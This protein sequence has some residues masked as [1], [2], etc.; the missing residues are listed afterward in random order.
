[1]FTCSTNWSWA[2]S[3]LTQPNLFNCR[4]LKHGKSSNWNLCFF[5][6]TRGC[7]TANRIQRI[8]FTWN[9]WKSPRFVGCVAKKLFG[10]SQATGGSWSNLHL[11]EQRSYCPQGWRHGIDMLWKRCMEI[12]ATSLIVVLKILLPFSVWYSFCWFKSQL[13][14]ELFIHH[15]HVR[16]TGLVRGLLLQRGYRCLHALERN[17]LCSAT[18]WG[19]QK[20]PTHLVPALVR[21]QDL[22]S[23]EV[24]SFCTAWRRL[25]AQRQ[26]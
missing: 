16:W 9:I 2:I 12:V 13:I 4:F 15:L 14:T 21:G 24:L 19:P 26:G 22:V 7:I 10:T 6:K 1:M 25:V 20:K 8:Q 23:D 18:C 11:L 5:L 17:F 3:E